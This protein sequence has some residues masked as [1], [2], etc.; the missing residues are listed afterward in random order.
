[1]LLFE[2]AKVWDLVALLVDDGV[3]IGVVRL[4]IEMGSG[5]VWRERERDVA[6]GE[7]RRFYRGRL[8]IL[9]VQTAI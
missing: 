3:S 8:G 2:V 5:E 9:G 1:M 6:G 4:N 7:V